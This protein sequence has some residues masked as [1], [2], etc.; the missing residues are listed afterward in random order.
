VYHCIV[1]EKSVSGLIAQD[2]R[3]RVR[4]FGS[5][6]V[7]VRIGEV[8]WHTS[9]FPNR[10]TQSYLLLLSKKIITQIAAVV[11][12]EITVVLQLRSL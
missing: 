6:P 12:D 10:R 11:G 9:L 8:Q 2:P 1:I 3:T 5:V 4:G 7:I